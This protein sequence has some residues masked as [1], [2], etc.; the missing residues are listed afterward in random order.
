MFGIVLAN[1]KVFLL[2]EG[3]VITSPIIVDFSDSLYLKILGWKQ[4]NYQKERKKEIIRNMLMVQNKIK[5]E[6]YPSSLTRMK[7]SG[8]LMNFLEDL[9]LIE[10]LN[11]FGK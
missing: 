1:G 5:L 11:S 9:V 2:A 4:K 7:M 3:M 6:W 10:I 8:Q